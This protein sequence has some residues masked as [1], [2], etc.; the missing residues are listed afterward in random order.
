MRTIKATI[1][2]GYTGADV[3]FEFEVPDDA[4][5]KEINELCWEYATDYIQVDWEDKVERSLNRG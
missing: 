1:S 3:E 4:T 5:E 2:L